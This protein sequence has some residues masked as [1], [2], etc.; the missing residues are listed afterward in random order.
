MNKK[1]IISDGIE[2]FIWIFL[3]ACFL[4]SGYLVWHHGWKM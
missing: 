1:Q 2:I 4:G 3:F